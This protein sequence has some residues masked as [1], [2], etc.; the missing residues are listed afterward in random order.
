MEKEKLSHAELQTRIAVIK[1][2]KS[3][4]QEQREKFSQYLFIL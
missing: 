3:L 1:R 2:F 4:L